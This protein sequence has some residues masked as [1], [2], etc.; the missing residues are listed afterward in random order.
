MTAT[1]LHIVQHLAPGGLETLVLEM[2][3]RDPNCHIVS[4]EDTADA[5]I[6]NWPRLAEHSE[7]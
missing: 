6:G 5:A 3:A 1:V 2:Q 7:R 4:L